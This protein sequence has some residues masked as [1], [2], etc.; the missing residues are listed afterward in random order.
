[1]TAGSGILHQE[2]PKG[3]SRGR[4]R[5]FQLWANLPANLKMTDPCYQDIPSL[6]VAH[7][8]PPCDCTMVRLM[9][10]PI[11]LPCGLVVKKAEKIWPTF[12]ASSPGPVSLTEN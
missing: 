3:D 8:R 5:G 9:A 6:V 1:M 4:M 7:N 10:S 12:P 11:P 2:M